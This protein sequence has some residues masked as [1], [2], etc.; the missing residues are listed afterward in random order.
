MQISKNI[1]IYSLN[2]NEMY[3]NRGDNNLSINSFFT[4]NN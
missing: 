2:K 3:I 4:N 1:F